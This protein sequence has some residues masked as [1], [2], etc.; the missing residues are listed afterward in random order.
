VLAGVLLD[1]QFEADAAQALASDRPLGYS[2]APERTEEGAY[3]DLNGP[4]EQRCYNHIGLFYGASPDARDGLA[5][6]LGLP[7]ERAESCP[8][9]YDMAAD[10]WGAVFDTMNDLSTGV[11]M[12]FQ[13]GSGADSDIIN[14][15]LAAEVDSMNAD[16]KLPEEITVTVTQCD[17]PNA[18]YDPQEVSI[19]FCTEFV[20]HLEE[21]FDAV[22]AD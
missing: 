5:E 8:E 14:R 17:E 1:W 6:D 10:S 3:W 4:E 13:P 18:F 12:V 11:P 19:T 22:V 20:A 21:I 16:L 2:N 9:E 15:V 7:E